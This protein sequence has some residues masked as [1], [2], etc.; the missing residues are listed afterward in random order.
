MSLVFV[1]PVYNIDLHKKYQI[2]KI[3]A[4]KIARLADTDDKRVSLIT[5]LLLQYAFNK[6]LGI[7][8]IDYKIDKNGKPYAKGCYFSISHSKKLVAVVVDDKKVGLDIQAVKKV[9]E[10]TV[11]WCLNEYEMNNFNDD[12]N[13]FTAIWC[14][15]EAFCKYSGKGMKKP[16]KKLKTPNSRL[17]VIDYDGDRYFLSVYNKKQD[18]IQIE[19]VNEIESI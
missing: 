14:K 1:T 4:E 7:P 13:Y 6:V 2:S 9:N 15:K 16:F 11:Q 12:F 10:K 8:F 17:E 19:V 18:D 3:R 5:E